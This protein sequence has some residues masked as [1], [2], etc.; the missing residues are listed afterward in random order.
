MIKN[1]WIGIDDYALLVDLPS[2]GTFRGY[3]TLNK[4]EIR[5]AKDCFD[6]C[7]RNSANVKTCDV[8]GDIVDINDVVI[9]KNVKINL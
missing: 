9:Y 6:F 4:L 5:D 7:H 8:D 1:D 2:D 3:V